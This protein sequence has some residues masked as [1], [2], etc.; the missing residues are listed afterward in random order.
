MNYDEHTSG[1]KEAGSVSSMSYAENS[2][3]ETINQAKDSSRIVGAIPF[4]TRAWKETPE[5]HSDGTG[6]FVEDAANG[7]YYLAS[8]ALGMEAAEKAY[9]RAGVK[10][11]FDK[12]TGQNFVTY[13]KGHTTVSIWLEDETSV[14]SRLELMKKYNLAG[15]AYWSLGQEKADIWNI[16]D[17]YFE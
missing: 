2:I 1:S 9:N 10:P 17:Q 6:V 5:E 3:K 12:T 7:N 4:Y 15:A 14:K 8:E 13:Q 11:S 16:I